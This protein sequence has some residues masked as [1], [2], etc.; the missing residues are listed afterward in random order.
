MY[1]ITVEEVYT[2]LVSKKDI[3]NIYNQI[4]KREICENA[5]AFHNYDHIKNVSNIAEKVLIDLN[6]DNH[7]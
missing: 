5:R 1:N 2:N 3:L 4:E 7:L 6:F